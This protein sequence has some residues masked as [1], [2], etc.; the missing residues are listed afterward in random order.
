MLFMQHHIL[1]FKND[2][3]AHF[4][5]HVVGYRRSVTGDFGEVTILLDNIV[6]R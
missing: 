3:L 4:A 2:R 6:S 5:C 1:G